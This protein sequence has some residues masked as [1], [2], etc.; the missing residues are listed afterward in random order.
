MNK[1][2][3]FYFLYLIKNI[4]SEPLNDCQIGSTCDGQICSTHGNCALNIYNFYNDTSS[5]LSLNIFSKKV[6]CYCHKGYL[7]YYPNSYKVFNDYKDN[8]LLDEYNNSSIILCCYKQKKQMAAFLLE[9]IFGFGIGHFYLGNY[10][11]AVGKL[12]INVGLII[13]G[14]FTLFIFC[15]A[16]DNNEKYNNTNFIY[17][18][19]INVVMGII[20]LLIAFQFVD[21]CI[22][23]IGYHTD[24]YGQKI[25]LW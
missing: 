1:I 21:I 3:K 14:G 11:F 9:L 20:I 10:I 4:F 8:N 22:L 12:L 7:T 18:P 16:D 15:S 13:I 2:F 6:T 25:D 5:N 19:S 17:H 23:G 24:G